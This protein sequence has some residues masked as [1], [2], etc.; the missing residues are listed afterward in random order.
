MLGVAGWL[1]FE[2]DR[3][4]FSMQHLWML[5][6]VV[7]VWPGCSQACALVRF[8]IPPRNRVAKR[9]QSV[10]PNNSVLMCCA[11]LARASS[12]WANNVARAILGFCGPTRVKDEPDCNPKIIGKV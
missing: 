2:N 1:K 3:L 12:C 5:H 9:T 7:V 11:R 6:N 10:A 4:E 8:S